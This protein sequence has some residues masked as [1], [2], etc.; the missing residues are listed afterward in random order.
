MLEN[1]PVVAEIFKIALFKGI[2][3]HPTLKLSYALS[4]SNTFYFPLVILKPIK[5]SLQ[6]TYF[7]CAY[8][9]KLVLHVQYAGIHSYRG[10]GGGGGGAW[11]TPPPPRK[12]PNLSPPLILW[13]PLIQTVNSTN[14]NTDNKNCSGQPSPFMTTFTNSSWTSCS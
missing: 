8:E 7:L 5:C 3:P 1:Q 13:C 2:C 4:L 10:W 12:S 14:R 11:D 9:G 6:L